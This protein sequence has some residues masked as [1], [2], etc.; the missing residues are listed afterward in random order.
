MPVIPAAVTKA[1]ISCIIF[2]KCHK[3][4][5]MTRTV[6]IS[7]AEPALHRTVDLLER[8]FLS[9]RRFGICLWDGTELPADGYPSF[10]LVLNHAGALRRICANITRSH[11][12]TGSSAWRNAAWQQ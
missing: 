2:N 7:N 11:Y 12:V 6:S 4:L 3:E 10:H 8:L 1:G 5:A 9:P